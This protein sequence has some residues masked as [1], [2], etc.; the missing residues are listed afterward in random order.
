MNG[1]YFGDNLGWLGNRDE[2]PNESVDLVAAR[3]EKQTEML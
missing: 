1:L 2:F 3:K